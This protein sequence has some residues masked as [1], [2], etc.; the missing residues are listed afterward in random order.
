MQSFPIRHQFILMQFCP[1]F[2]KAFL[3][4][5]QGSSNHFDRIYAEDTCFF[6]V[7]SVKMRDTMWCP[8]LCKHPNDN[9]EESAQLRHEHI[10]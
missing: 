4:P 1:C 10:L 9:P 5:W 3:P 8:D 7:V 6:L 2:N